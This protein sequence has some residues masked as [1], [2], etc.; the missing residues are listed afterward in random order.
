MNKVRAVHSLIDRQRWQKMGASVDRAADS[1]LDL[2]FYRAKTGISLWLQSAWLFGF[3]VIG[4]ILWA[5]I[6]NWGQINF[7]Y[8]DWAEGIG[9]RVAFLQNAVLTDQLPL[10]MPDPSA[11]RNVTDRYI[12]VPDTIMSP[13]VLL[14][15]YMTLGNFVVFNTVFLYILGF[16]GMWQISRRYSLSPI[17]FTA[18][19]FIFAFNGRITDLIVVGDIHWAGYFLMP[20]FV[21]FMLQAIEG[22]V[23]WAWTFKLSLFF[24]ILYLQGSFHLFTISLTFMMLTGLFNFRLFL[25]MLRGGTFAIFASMVRILPAALVSG[26]FDV[27]FLSG[28]D[29]FAQLVSSMMNLKLAVR[30]QVFRNTPLNPLGWWEMDHYIGLLGFIFL[31]VFCLSVWVRRREGQFDYRELIIP[32]M[33]MVLFSVG[34][35]FKPISMLEIPILSSQRVSTRF[36]VLALVV[37]VIL[38]GI[39]MQRYLNNGRPIRQVRI[40]FL[41]GFLILLNDI[42]QHEKLWRVAHLSDMFPAREVDLG[43][44]Y[45][46]NHPDPPYMTALAA[47]LVISI[48]SLLFLGWMAVREQSERMATL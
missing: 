1:L 25:P 27:A 13:Q 20:W 41:A 33:A 17:P 4:A 14:L 29:T 21:Y 26:K 19:F 10:H 3:L 44:A 16:L 15:S 39:G 6:L 40:A 8:H 2:L 47:G 37:M 36:F 42:W 23:G 31:L 5:Y 43:L 12:S 45:V 7:M 46:A 34:R 32:V 24:L 30:D 48:F 28:F 9:H 22:P 18:M 38:A 11:L 35:I